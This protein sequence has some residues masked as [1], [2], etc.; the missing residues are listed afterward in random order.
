MSKRHRLGSWKTVELF[1]SEPTHIYLCRYDVPIVK[2]WRVMAHARIGQWQ[3]R[4]NM[5]DNCYFTEEKARRAL[6]DVERMM[7]AKLAVA[8]LGIR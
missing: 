5:F 7:M 6:V 2:P 3:N 8:A 1:E 4:F